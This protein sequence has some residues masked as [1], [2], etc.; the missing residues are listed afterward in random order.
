MRNRELY[1][2]Q[3]FIGHAEVAAGFAEKMNRVVFADVDVAAVLRALGLTVGLCIERLGERK[4]AVDKILT[5][6]C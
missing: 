3:W 6:G 2:L 4:N 5:C 1:L